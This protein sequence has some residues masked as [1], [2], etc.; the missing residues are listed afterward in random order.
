MKA[1]FLFGIL[2]AS[3]FH[4][5]ADTSKSQDKIAI[6]NIYDPL[7]YVEIIERCKSFNKYD[8]KKIIFK[9]RKILYKD[10]T[11]NIKEIVSADVDM[12]SKIL[13]NYNLNSI[14]NDS[15]ADF[16]AEITIKGEIIHNGNPQ[17][18]E[19]L[20]YSEIGQPNLSKFARVRSIKNTIATLKGIGELYKKL[21]FDFNSISYSCNPEDFI[22]YYNLLKDTTQVTNAKKYLTLKREI[23][24]FT[25][26][27]ISFYDLI[28]KITEKINSL[29]I[30]STNVPIN[31]FERDLVYIKN[32]LEIK[33]DTL[34]LIESKKLETINS[35]FYYKSN[36]NNILKQKQI[37][38]KEITNLD[39]DSVHFKIQNAY[40][41]V[42]D[43]QKLLRVITDHKTHIQLYTEHITKNENRILIQIIAE[44]SKSSINSD[45]LVQLAKETYE[46]LILLT[47]NELSLEKDEQSV[48]GI[49]NAVRILEQNLLTLANIYDD[50]LFEDVRK[51]LLDNLTPTEISL[52]NIG[53]S[54][55]DRIILTIM[56]KLNKSDND[57]PRYAS[58]SFNFT[59]SNFGFERR[60]S[61]SFIFI[62]RLSIDKWTKT[63]SSE[64]ELK[65]T[66]PKDVNYE[67]CAGTTLYWNWNSRNSF[68]KLLSP[69]F[70]INVSFPRFGTIEKF[71]TIDSVG[72]KTTRTEDKINSI[73]I[74]TGIIVSLFNGA[75][76]INYGGA[77]T[78]GNG[79]NK[80]YFGIG[81]SFINLSQKFGNIISTK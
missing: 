65:E 52:P 69:G 23:E 78:A 22:N 50:D 64:Y 70:G 21:F 46:Q 39:Q 45:L 24:N 2:T 27:S 10:S 57:S 79:A 72:N 9:D 37:A 35:Y 67:P 16:E 44:R 59:I 71:I 43:F 34:D 62:K 25:R 68:M 60:V 80:Q 13:I 42:I 6:H 73:D 11:D 75:V 38:I 36:L 33:K 30:S 61:D 14:W 29:E 49:L 32:S 81:F 56:N 47:K 40:R 15:D 66:K 51:C 26:D 77:L 41:V 58:R 7:Q 55:G 63:D 17:N 53:V 74:G 20:G 4:V 3:V 8:D 5:L 31:K 48:R 76:Y 54:A 18:I 28:S 1:L 19:I 12:D